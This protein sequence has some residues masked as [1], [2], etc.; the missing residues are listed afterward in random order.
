MF[1]WPDGGPYHPEASSK[2]FDRKIR[3]AAFA[4]LPVIRLHDLRHT[5][6]TLVWSPAST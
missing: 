3:Q 4:D 2:S 1:C 5:W 6:A